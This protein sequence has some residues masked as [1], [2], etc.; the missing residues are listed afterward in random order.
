MTHYEASSQSIGDIGY[1]DRAIRTGLGL[2]ILMGA[3]H[4]S[5]EN[6]VAYPYLMLFAT[7]MVFSGMIGWDPFYAAAK[8]M[9]SGMKR[10]EFVTLSVGNINMADRLIR[11]FLG[12]A[13]LIYSIALIPGGA[14]AL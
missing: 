14:E 3:L 13:I 2:A 7:L 9:V 4:V 1:L 6:A 12:S 8:K 5:I 10:I 11:I